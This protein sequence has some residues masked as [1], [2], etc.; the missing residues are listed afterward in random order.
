MICYVFA[1]FRVHLILVLNVHEIALLVQL[2]LVRD[3]RETAHIAMVVCVR[4][5][6]AITTNVLEF[7]QAALICFRVP[8][9]P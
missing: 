5:I 9:S 4:G 3:L 1:L 7:L 2:A 8:S 6:L